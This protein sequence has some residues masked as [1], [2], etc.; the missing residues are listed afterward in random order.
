M[1]LHRDEAGQPQPVGRVQHLGE[2]PGEH[3]RGADVQRLA[4]FHHVVQRRERLLDRRVVIEAVDL[5]QV[6][7]IGSQ[8]AQAVVDRMHDV[9]ARQTALVRAVAHRR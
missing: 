8:P 2:L 5:I 4:C 9:L 6:H 3:R 7:V 1:V